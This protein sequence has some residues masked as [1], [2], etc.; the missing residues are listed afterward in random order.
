MLATAPTVPNRIASHF[1]PTPNPVPAT[2]DGKAAA[3]SEAV[4]AAMMFY[5]S[6]LAHPD[7]RV[8]ERAAKAIFDLEKTRLRHGRELAGTPA[9]VPT[10]AE[11]K[12]PTK[13]DVQR[14]GRIAELAMEAD[15][16]EYHEDSFDE[17]EDV[18]ER[19]EA[20]AR[21][22][23]FLPLL[24]GAR[25]YLHAQGRSATDAEVKAFAKRQLTE[26]L[27]GRADPAERGAIR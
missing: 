11:P 8:A 16:I 20:F 19:I 27:L 5:Q 13:A 25:E 18:R 23:E 17:E 26:Q 2:P 15:A 9:P 22:E 12:P 1:A 21:S 7:E 6:Q 4:F 24:R 10:A 14:L 3:W